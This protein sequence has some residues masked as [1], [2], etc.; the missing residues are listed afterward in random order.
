MADIDD[1][2]VSIYLELIRRTYRAHLERCSLRDKGVR[3]SSADLQKQLTAEAPRANQSK[4][5]AAK[6]TQD[7]HTVRT[8]AGSAAPLQRWWPIPLTR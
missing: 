1:Q 4:A 2:R 8:P 6:G 3:A 5:S 7:S